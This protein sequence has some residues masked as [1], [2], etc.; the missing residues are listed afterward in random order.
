MCK[1]CGQNDTTCLYLGN[2]AINKKDRT[3]QG[4]KICEFANHELQEMKHESV[5]PDS[6]LRLKINEE[7]SSNNVKNNTFA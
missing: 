2:I 1:P 3:G 7:L 4:L 5:D 6:D